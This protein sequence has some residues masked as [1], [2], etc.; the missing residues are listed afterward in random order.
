MDYYPDYYIG[1]MTGTSCD[2]SDLVLTDSSATKC[3]AHSFKPYPD[4]LRKALLSLIKKPDCP[5]NIWQ[6]CKQDY[7]RFLADHIKQFHH[8]HGIKGARHIVGA[9]G[10]T[11]YHRPDQAS[12]L[13]MLDSALLSR[14]TNCLVIYDFRSKDIELGGQGAPLAGLYHQYLSQLYT[15]SRTAWVNIGGI[16]NI[17]IT[18]PSDQPLSYDI[19]P[20]CSLLDA[21]FQ[22]HHPDKSFD[23]NDQ[24]AQAGT[25]DTQLLERLSEHPFL[26]KPW[27]RSAC[28]NDFSL[29]WLQSISEGLKPADIQCTLVHF[30]AKIIHMARQKHHANHTILHGGGCKHPL[31]W[32]LLADQSEISTTEQVNIDPDFFEGMLIAW[33]AKS[34]CHSEPLD[35]HNFTGGQ[36]HLLGRAAFMRE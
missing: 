22:L 26:S 20:G 3:L 35:T 18:D 30:S 27:P 13:Q 33:L 2:G 14:Q 7:T 1:S 4:P 10:Q 5:P 34:Y 32:K 31:L 16:S 21:H 8:H 24:W 11:I 19:G 12:T 6:Q 17:T 23:H 28:R 15:L 29:Q 25:C 9:H 36:K